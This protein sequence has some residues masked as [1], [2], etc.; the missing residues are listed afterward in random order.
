LQ[1]RVEDHNLGFAKV[2]NQLTDEDCKNWIRH[3][4]VSNPSGVDEKRTTS[5]A[6][7]RMEI[8]GLVE[9]TPVPRL[10]VLVYK[11]LQ[12]IYVYLIGPFKLYINGYIYIMIYYE[13]GDPMLKA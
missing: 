6:K 12:F 8:K 5:L 2:D 7:R 1:P 11:R 3:R 9:E 4:A 13:S 10:Y